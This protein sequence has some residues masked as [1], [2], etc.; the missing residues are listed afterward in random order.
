MPDTTHADEV[1]ILLVDD[2]LDH[3]Q[4]AMR[5]LRSES[6]WRVEAVRLGKECIERAAEEPFDLIILD[7][8]LPDMSGIDV[9]RKIRKTSNVPVI[10]MTSQGSEEV[11]I[12]ALKEGATAYL[13]KN[14]DLGRRLSFEIRECI[15][16]SKGV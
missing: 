7:Y 8:R 16:Q 2:N 3:V 11:A 9:L 15:E 5:A 1:R 6:S 12:Q 13:V 14:H 10:M 4:L